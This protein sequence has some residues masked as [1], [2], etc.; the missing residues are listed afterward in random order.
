MLLVKQIET[1][2]R[3]LQETLSNMNIKQAGKYTFVIQTNVQ[4]SI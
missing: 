4:Y 1:K 3:L 2:C